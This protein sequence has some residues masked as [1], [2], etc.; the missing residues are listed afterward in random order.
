M[1]FKTHDVGS[2]VSFKTIAGEEVIGKVVECHDETLIIYKPM[3]ILPSANGIGLLNYMITIDEDAEIEFNH[4]PI[5][6][7]HKSADGVTKAYIEKTS[8]LIL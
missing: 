4:E 7:L 1:K 3:I 6:A 5:M 2:V 8:G